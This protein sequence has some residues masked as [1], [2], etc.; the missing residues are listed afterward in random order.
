MKPLPMSRRNYLFNSLI[1]WAIG[2]ELVI[3]HHHRY[4]RRCTKNFDFE[5][6]MYR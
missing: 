6:Q 2:H 4:C 5:R 3:R 1:C